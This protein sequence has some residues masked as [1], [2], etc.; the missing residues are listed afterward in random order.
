MY[1]N[2]FFL[3]SLHHS[4][5]LIFW[6]CVSLVKEK[7]KAQLFF[8][9]FFCLFVFLGPHPWHMEGPRLGVELEL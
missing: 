2:D 4:V 5:L 3:T 6:L 8:F 1:K 7:K 9:F